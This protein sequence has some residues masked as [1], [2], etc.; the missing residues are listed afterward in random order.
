MARSYTIIASSTDKVKNL[1]TNDVFIDKNAPSDFYAYEGFP[2]ARISNVF[3]KPSNAYYY[4]TDV[5]SITRLIL[6]VYGN[7]DAWNEVYR[8]SPFT[9]EDSHVVDGNSIGRATP[10]F[11]QPG[12][13]PS[14]SNTL[15]TNML[16]IGVSGSASIGDQLE[17]VTITRASSG[18]QIVATKTNNTGEITVT[19]VASDF[20]DKVV[21]KRLLIEIQG[22][23][24]GGGK[25]GTGI[26]GSNGNGGGAGGYWCGIIDV[27]NVLYWEIYMGAPGSNGTSSGGVGNDGEDTSL[28][29]CKNVVSS[30]VRCVLVKGGS[31]ADYA[32]STTQASGG[33]VID[34]TSSYHYTLLTAT[35]GKGGVDGTS[36]DDTSK[37]Y[38]RCTGTAATF[39]EPIQVTRGGKWG[40]SNLQGGNGGGA[41]YFANGGF[42]SYFAS[43]GQYVGDGSAGSGGGGSAYDFWDSPRAGVGGA[44]GIVIWY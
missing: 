26:G 19:K 30:L 33:G 3:M 41:S 11:V 42:G 2:M 1:G 13:R 28:Y 10:T 23:G 35:G 24:G 39:E 40:G 18:L 29:Y 14:F 43:N 6:D 7:Y 27:D 5:N 17:S 31:G 22:S 20:P 44:S 15:Y 9:Y 4:C 16:H 38:P 12:T 25:G 32:S 37:I 8:G 36:P 34:Y 21:P